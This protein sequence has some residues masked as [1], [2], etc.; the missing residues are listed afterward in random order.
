MMPKERKR[1]S[2]E[3]RREKKYDVIYDNCF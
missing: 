3:K 1:G 2:R